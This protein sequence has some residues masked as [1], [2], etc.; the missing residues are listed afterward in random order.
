MPVFKLTGG[1]SSPSTHDTAVIPSSDMLL[2][3]ITEGFAEAESF[4]EQLAAEA[5]HPKTSLGGVRVSMCNSQAVVSL[6]GYEWTLEDEVNYYK[7]TDKQALTTFYNSHMTIVGCEECS[8]LATSVQVALTCHTLDLSRWKQLAFPIGFKQ[9]W[10]EQYEL[11]GEQ[12]R[13]FCAVVSRCVN[14][15]GVTVYD[16]CAGNLNISKGMLELGASN[17]IAVELDPD[18]VANC[19]DNIE[20]NPI[21]MVS[22][23][24]SS[25][26]ALRNVIVVSNPPWGMRSDLALKMVLNLGVCAIH[27]FVIFRKSDWYYYRRYLLAQG[28]K[29]RLVHEFDYP[30][31]GHLDHKLASYQVNAGIYHIDSQAGDV[32]LEGDELEE[33]DF[34]HKYYTVTDEE[35]KVYARSWKEQLKQDKFQPTDTCWFRL[36]T[37]AS[38]ANYDVEWLVGKPR[39]SKDWHSYF[40]KYVMF[41]GLML[42]RLLDLKHN[43]TVQSD[44]AE[45]YNMRD[46]FD[47]LTKGLVNITRRHWIRVRKSGSIKTGLLKSVHNSVTMT[48]DGVNVKHV[49]AKEDFAVYS[50]LKGMNVPYLVSSELKETPKG[51][52]LHRYGMSRYTFQDFA[53]A[54]LEQKYDVVREVLSAFA[55]QFDVCPNVESGVPNYWCC[56][57][58]RT[59]L[60]NMAWYVMH[61]WLQS[62]SYCCHVGNF[63]F[64]L[65]PDNI[66]C[67]AGNLDFGDYDP[68]RSSEL[69]V[70]LLPLRDVIQSLWVQFGMPIFTDVVLP[71][72]VGD[73]IMDVIESGIYDKDAWFDLLARKPV[74]TTVS[75]LFDGKLPSFYKQER[76]RND[77]DAKRVIWSTI[78]RYKDC[79]QSDLDAT[80]V[81]DE[82]PENSAF[83]ELA[84]ASFH[85]I[86]SARLTET[87]TFD[88][89]LKVFLTKDYCGY[90]VQ[91]GAYDFLNTKNNGDSEKEMELVFTLITNHRYDIRKEF[92]AYLPQYNETVT[93]RDVLI[94]KFL[95]FPGIGK[96]PV[97]TMNTCDHKFCKNLSS[98]PFV[99]MS[100][101]P[102][103]FA[104]CTKF[105]S[106]PRTGLLNYLSF[107]RV[108]PAILK[109]DS[110]GKYRIEVDYDLVEF[111]YD[112]KIGVSKFHNPMKVVD[113]VIE[114]DEA[115]YRPTEE[116]IRDDL[117][118]FGL[119]E[120][121][122]CSDSI[123]II[124]YFMVKSTILDELAKVGELPKLR[125]PDDQV[126]HMSGKSAGV[127]LNQFGWDAKTAY[128]VLHDTHI[129]LLLHTS[130]AHV[131]AVTKVNIKQQITPK[132]RAR[133]ITGCQLSVTTAGRFCFQHLRELLMR[134]DIFKIGLGVTRGLWQRS[135]RWHFGFQHEER[136]AEE[137]GQF[138]TRFYR[139]MGHD[140][141]KFDRKV[142]RTMMHMIHVMICYIIDYGPDYTREE[143]DRGTDIPET[144]L[145]LAYK[146]Y[147]ARYPDLT[148]KEIA[149]RCV[150]NITTSEYINLTFNFMKYG[151][152]LYMKP[153]GISS[154]GSH[155]AD[156]NGYNHMLL[157]HF[158]W[159]NWVSGFN[160][161]GAPRLDWAREC[162]MDF[163]LKPLR[164]WKE[165]ERKCKLLDNIQR[166]E[167]FRASLLS[168]DNYMLVRANYTY[169][170]DDFA[171]YAFASSNFV[172][173]PDKFFSLNGAKP[174]T[175]F[176]SQMC[177][178]D[179]DDNFQPC[180]KPSKILS[181]AVL[182][183]ITS[184]AKVYG[185]Y[186]K[187]DLKI[188]RLA[189]LA[190][191]L[192]P[193]RWR[194]GL[195]ECVKHLSETIIDYLT[196]RYKNMELTAEEVSAASGYIPIG[197]HEMFSWYG[198]DTAKFFDIENVKRMYEPADTGVK[199]SRVMYL[200]EQHLKANPDCGLPKVTT[201]GLEVV[202]EDDEESRRESAIVTVEAQ[203]EPP[204][205][206][207]KCDHACGEL[208]QYHCVDC[209]NYGLA[210]C[211]RCA[212]DHF[213]AVEHVH[214]RCSNVALECS[215]CGQSDVRNLYLDNGLVRCEEHIRVG[216][217]KF[218]SHETFYDSVGI[219]IQR[220][221]N[222]ELIDY[223][224]KLAKFGHRSNEM[225]L[226]HYKCI[227]YNLGLFFRVTHYEV[228]QQLTDA[229]KAVKYEVDKIDIGPVGT[230]VSLKKLEGQ[231]SGMAQSYKVRRGPFNVATITLRAFRGG[232]FLVNFIEGKN[233][234]QV[235]D[236]VYP[237]LITQPLIRAQQVLATA[238]RSPIM[239][240]LAF[241]R[242]QVLDLY[243]EYKTDVSGLNNSQLVAFKSVFSKNITYIQGPPG[244]GKTQTATAIVVEAVSRGM[245][246]V[247]ASSAHNAVDN[248]A[249]RIYKKLPRNVARN[250]PTEHADR[251]HSIA[252]PYKSGKVS[253]LATT[254]ATNIPTAYTHGVDLLLVDESS[255][256]DDVYL[257]SIVASVK[258]TCIVFLGDHLQLAPVNMFAPELGNILNYYAVTQ[259]EKVI[260][261]DI[262]FRMHQQISD[263]ISEQFY[264]GRLRCGTKPS[265]D[266]LGPK[267]IRSVMVPGRST[268]VKNTT[269]RV[270]V[271]EVEIAQR[272]ADVLIEKAGD[273]TIR[274]IC[275]YEGTRSALMVNDKIIVS[276]VDAS[277]G[278]ED[279]IIVVLTTDT[280]SEFSKSRQRVN[281]A[282]SRAK[283]YLFIL[284][285]E[286]LPPPYPQIEHEDPLG[287]L[288]E[289]NN[290]IY[291]TEGNENED[292]EVEIEGKKTFPPN[293]IPYMINAKRVW[294]EN[295]HFLLHNATETY[296]FAFSDILA[297]DVE[298][299]SGRIFFETPLGH[300]GMSYPVQLGYCT[301][302]VNSYQ[303]FGTHYCQPTAFYHDADGRVCEEPRVLNEHEDV[304]WYI[305]NMP[306][307]AKLKNHSYGSKVTYR[308][309]LDA[310]LDQLRRSVVR[311]VV[312]L[313]WAAEMEFCTLCPV[314]TI[315]RSVPNRC[316]KCGCCAPFYTTEP[317]CSRC[318]GNKPYTILNPIFVDLQLYYIDYFP[319]AKRNL[320]SAFDEVVGEA[321][322]TIL[323][324]DARYDAYM[325]MAL[326]QHWRKRSIPPISTPVGAISRRYAASVELNRRIQDRV[327][328]YVCNEFPSVVDIGCGFKPLKVVNKY[329]E[330]TGVDPNVQVG[331]THLTHF[332]RESY[333]DHVGDY[334]CFIA[335]HSLYYVDVLREPVG[336]ALLH[337]KE[338]ITPDQKF[339][340][341]EDE[342]RYIVYGY[343][344]VY[345]NELLTLDQLRARFPD[346]NVTLCAN[347]PH[348]CGDQFGDSV[349]AKSPYCSQ[350][351]CVFS[352]YNHDATFYIVGAKKCVKA[353]KVDALYKCTSLLQRPSLLKFERKVVVE[354]I[355]LEEFEGDGNIDIRQPRL[356]GYESRVR[357]PHC[358]L[359]SVTIQ[360]TPNKVMSV[361]YTILQKTT[362]NPGSYLI[363]GAAGFRGDSP[364]YTW[365][366][367]LL[368]GLYTL[369]D[370]NLT[371]KPVNNDIF[372]R[373]TLQDALPK[374]LFYGLIIC[375]VYVTTD[376]L[377]FYNA[378]DELVKKHNDVVLA[379]KVTS[380]T[381]DAEGL[382]LV[383]SN[384]NN[385]YVGRAPIM[386]VTSEGWFI[387]WR[388]VNEPKQHDMD[389]MYRRYLSGLAKED[390]LAPRVVTKGD[391]ALLKQK[392]K[393]KVEGCCAANL[394]QVNF[395]EDKDKSQRT[396]KFS[397]T[398]NNKWLSNMYLCDIVVDGVKYNSV[399]DYYQTAKFNHH[400]KYRTWYYST[401]P[402]VIKQLSK[403]LDLDPSW[404]QVKQSIMKR[405]MLAKYSRPEFKQALIRTGNARLFEDTTDL[406]WGI[407]T[408]QRPG[409]NICGAMLE[410]IRRELIN[411]DK[412][413]F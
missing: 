323:E 304:I 68:S 371:M 384:F 131:P 247:V 287:F 274:F 259:N 239:L 290:S 355:G 121:G 25:A 325:T 116:A 143:L 248:L 103:F 2:N 291:V 105:P 10:L 97:D 101:A 85:F 234:I 252:P 321:P 130:D 222:P 31:E 275:M 214:Y 266:Y 273:K 223:V 365:M 122:S 362:F 320:K 337:L 160:M 146:E 126:K 59:A 186:L 350:L 316:F 228:A 52:V 201:E 277:Q 342:V 279:D 13:V 72:K 128:G 111:L 115:Y 413:C 219:Q 278:K 254:L 113:T 286:E 203:F 226:L 54:V 81:L 4:I 299:V 229:K 244:T 66:D 70:K 231:P 171:K 375:D 176:C 93:D 394:D 67:V 151:L 261:L 41:D 289:L 35:L 217:I 370:P 310:F 107:G 123:G 169:D 195:P 84:R 235:G 21:T 82:E 343:N 164:L 179:P 326:Y 65:T 263:Y 175:E 147:G 238:S 58:C 39:G 357:K 91:R 396:I 120:G 212:A 56:Q 99:F 225:R 110:V 399:E 23:D 354:A 276:T 313:T 109:N 33:P 19:R 344:N 379:V 298:G 242:I 158:V 213:S 353:A 63:D 388:M 88:E 270:N 148:P 18:V 319:D 53:D 302:F 163:R 387:F 349:I 188:V 42:Q 403:Q 95:R 178:V 60:N 230:V 12:L 271:A 165:V 211:P 98:E 8:T 45:G 401:A 324:H 194:P 64:V 296:T 409:S 390:E 55:L 139:T 318:I 135:L 224:N 385:V 9:R 30:I 382:D 284:S 391:L 341:F 285:T 215:V 180:P 330:L 189:S 294:V 347:V 183:G 104:A 71:R 345:I 400:N 170:F 15:R 295:K 191:L 269:T 410:E 205:T 327:L 48:P 369:V 6:E 340:W 43:I 162:V 92:Y 236:H 332:C 293:Y 28:R 312:F 16:L 141:S 76:L 78:N 34:E 333:Q 380:S 62:Y 119:V 256:V 258:P 301:G 197:S 44:I 398:K 133:T 185:K 29:L 240:Q 315:N 132:S 200:Y 159:L 125:L 74:Y 209:E 395:E 118:L 7:E 351:K 174:P 334:A 227:Y 306:N 193:V 150:Y 255:K 173:G 288:V 138:K 359:D 253:V 311:R 14:I 404:Y 260:M 336:Y 1:S 377:G 102:F 27:A 73:F 80:D 192:Y 207:R 406:Y 206:M 405:G 51:A 106:K 166:R 251:V 317:S 142:D 314:I 346:Y 281:V 246:V 11:K 376:H 69:I 282:C 358:D 392:I 177:V 96:V 373:E 144:F 411:G 303:S 218:Y 262:Q 155:T 145:T 124:R 367:K 383:A 249:D 204:K 283:D 368:P 381:F 100:M 257:F 152:D 393:N 308:T 79:P 47:S 50:V 77:I 307:R 397:I 202:V 5:C 37:E 172:F 220:L 75:K 272:L 267:R 243:I 94:P 250:I 241:N 372:L 339:T 408:K 190:T 181:S 134:A 168:D 216:N 17:V 83:V 49:R 280:S 233:N 237:D 117:D 292:V 22:A 140:C 322:F 86:K 87:L 305:P 36:Q 156:G 265:S 331:P 329:C 199:L 129:P 57:L 300:K 38:D 245:V 198:P 40:R 182:A 407:G 153:G 24:V 136:V 137:G 221:H 184:E 412:S 32:T 360:P 112:N 20:G 378:L 210:F 154:G 46:A 389:L 264:D 366:R 364:M 157:L 386:S 187:P 89:Y 374:M 196:K 402:M 167:S 114:V 338:N 328:D 363:V 297:I 268:I 127:P 108:T 61:I 335:V 352:M 149:R 348:H 309:M 208:A 90:D 3:N 26:P 161:P 361:I 356:P 232:D